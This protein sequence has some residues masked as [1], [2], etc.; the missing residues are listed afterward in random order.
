MAPTTGGFPEININEILLT[1]A[2]AEI[3][4]PAETPRDKRKRAD[5][6]DNAEDDALPDF[7][8]VRRAGICKPT[9][10]R[11]QGGGRDDVQ[12]SHCSARR[13]I[14]CKVQAL[15]SEFA[16]HAKPEA[17]VLCVGGAD[18]VCVVAQS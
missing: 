17:E 7:R 8:K 6:I 13:A 4:E 10:M 2:P 9:A 18:V 14:L 3:H 11:A 1:P 15:D 5:G 12:R 16:R